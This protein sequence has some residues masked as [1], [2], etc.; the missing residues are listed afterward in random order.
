MISNNDS[1]TVT[2]HQYGLYS[3]CHNI[4]FLYAFC[5]SNVL[6]EVEVLTFN[7]VLWEAETF[8]CFIANLKMFRLI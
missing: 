7:S 4:I 1:W 3:N 8:L 2:Q 6:V 5:S